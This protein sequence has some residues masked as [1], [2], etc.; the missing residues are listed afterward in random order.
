MIGSAAAASAAFR[1]PIL[2]RLQQSAPKLMGRVSRNGSRP[3]LP[4][5]MGGR[6]H[7]PNASPF[8]GFFREIFSSSVRHSRWQRLMEPAH[9]EDGEILGDKGNGEKC[10]EYPCVRRVGGRI[11]LFNACWCHRPR[12]TRHRKERG[13]KVRSRHDLFRSPPFMQRIPFFLLLLLFMDSRS[14]H[15]DC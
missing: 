10:T 2:R 6:V 12:I 9:G 13:R 11:L 8:N 7:V 5:E 1:T 3:T 15:V 14:Y 4:P